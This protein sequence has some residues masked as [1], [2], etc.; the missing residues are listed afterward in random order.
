[1]M[2]FTRTEW[3]IF[4]LCTIVG[5]LLMLFLGRTSAGV[6]ASSPLSSSMPWK[7]TVAVRTVAKYM[8]LVLT[9]LASISVIVMGLW[10]IWTADPELESNLGDTALVM[11]GVT[12]VIGIITAM[13]WD[14]S[15]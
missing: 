1:M 5:F 7:R 3:V 6:W 11:L 13:V 12:A 2:N 8:L 9:A 14:E 4:T 10:A 15:S